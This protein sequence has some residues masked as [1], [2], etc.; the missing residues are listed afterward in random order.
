[1]QQNDYNSENFYQSTA[2]RSALDAL[3]AAL[4]RN[5]TS[6]D[7]TSYEV[8]PKAYYLKF[9]PNH[10]LNNLSEVTLSFDKLFF[11]DNCAI[12]ARYDI[13][14]YAIINTDFS[15][16]YPENIESLKGHA[17]DIAYIT[18]NKHALELYIEV[19]AGLY[20]N[21]L[22]IADLMESMKFNK[23][24]EQLNLIRDMPGHEG[25]LA[26]AFP[27]LQVAEFIDTANKLLK[28]EY[29]I[30]FYKAVFP[31]KAYWKDH[32]DIEHWDPRIDLQVCL[33]NG[34]V[35]IMSISKK[36]IIF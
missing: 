31:I 1:M 23:D 34:N 6:F 21:K 19:V 33:V 36:I 13:G 24:N 17:L 18:R 26:P 4:L 15:I 9:G 25:L 35:K 5:E 10:D 14:K 28:D 3:L 20:Y 2:I 32:T 27:E 8:D 12:T 7:F 29:K 16:K 30:D 22:D 11:Y